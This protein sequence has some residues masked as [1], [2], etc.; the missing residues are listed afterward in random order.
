MNGFVNA[1]ADEK[2]RTTRN[3]HKVMDVM[4]AGWAKGQAGLDNRLK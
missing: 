3:F 1:S 2:G 4:M